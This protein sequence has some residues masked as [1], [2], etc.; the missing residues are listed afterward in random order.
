MRA[1]VGSRFKVSLISVAFVYIGLMS[2]ISYE[3]PLVF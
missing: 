2:F 1:I 3:C